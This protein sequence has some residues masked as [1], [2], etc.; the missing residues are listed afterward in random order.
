MFVRLS[1][2]LVLFAA[3][4]AHADVWK[5]V[6]AKGDTHFVDTDRPIYTWLDENGKVYYADKPGHDSAV[7]VELIWHSEGT[8]DEVEQERLSCVCS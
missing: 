7:S 2:L 6:D 4:S 5:W 8:L 3:C 1:A